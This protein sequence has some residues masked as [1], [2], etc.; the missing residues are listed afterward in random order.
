MSHKLAESWHGPYTVKKKE[1]RVNYQIDVGR[2]RAKVLHINNL[3]LFHVREEV[4]MRIAVIAEDWED[5]QAIGTRMCGTSEDCDPSLLDGVLKEFPAVMSDLPGKT[6]VCRLVIRTTGDQ[7][8]ASSPY[9]I[10]DTLKDRVREEVFKLVDLG[11]VVESRSPWVS[12]VVPVPKPDGSVRICIDYRRLNAVTIGDPYYMCTLDEIFEGVAASRVISK[13]DLAKGFYQIPVD[14]DSI[15]KTAFMTPFGKYAFRRMP[16]GL[17]KAPAIFQRTMEKVLAGCYGFSAP[18]IDNIVVFSK[19]GAEHIEHLR[20]VFQ[21]LG[22]HGLTVKASKCEFRKCQVEYLGHIIGNGVLAI[23]HHR[24]VAMA[25]YTTPRTKKHFRAFL[26]AASYYRRFV[27]GFAN[28]SSLLSSATSKAAPG[29]VGWM[30]V[31]LE[32]FHHLN[33]CI[34]NA[35]I[36]TIPS[37]EDIFSLHT[38]ASGAGIGATLNVTRDRKEFPVAFYSKQLQGGQHFY[39][40]T[41]LECLAIFKSIHYFTVLTDHRAF[42]SLLTSRVLNKRLHGW[43]LQ[44]LDF[45]FEIS[46]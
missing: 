34:Y 23:P 9:R 12:P 3:K 10:P 44:L 40:A 1:S 8:I 20:G 28:Y 42:V 33:I 6:D 18:Y 2:G 15:D 27:Q 7:P 36:L 35:C 37:S 22:K 41:E 43:V 31:M 13:L 19:T 5:D 26:G 45:D 32:A 21:A 29:V 25:E 38:D 16:F 14:E 46:Y 24:A 17:K 11:I 39:S 30:E 4:V